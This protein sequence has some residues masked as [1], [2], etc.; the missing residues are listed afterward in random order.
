VSEPLGRPAY[1]VYA[2]DSASDIWQ[3]ND[4]TDVRLL[5][6]FQA[7]KQTLRQEFVLHR[8]KM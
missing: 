1:L 4:E 8:R 2:S 3:W 6:V 5:L 7:G